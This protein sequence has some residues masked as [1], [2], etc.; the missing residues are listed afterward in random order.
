MKNLKENL[1]AIRN[2]FGLWAGNAALTVTLMYLFAGN[3]AP[4][5]EIVV[6][7]VLE[8]RFRLCVYVP[9]VLMTFVLNV[10]ICINSLFDILLAKLC[11]KKLKWGK[12]VHKGSS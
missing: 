2:K 1:Q 3:V 4:L 7:A 12:T 9:V 5:S 6:G 8:R 10:F 11:G